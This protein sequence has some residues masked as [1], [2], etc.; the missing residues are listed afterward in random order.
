MRH[1]RSAYILQPALTIAFVR[2]LHYLRIE[3]LAP[4]SGATALKHVRR[5]AS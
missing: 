3:P 1:A 2:T 4:I 5:A